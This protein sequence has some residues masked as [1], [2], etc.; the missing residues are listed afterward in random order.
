P[1]GFTHGTSEQRQRWFMI[2]FDQGS[3][4]ACN[5]FETDNL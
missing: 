4:D 1:E 5:T 2:G 3:V